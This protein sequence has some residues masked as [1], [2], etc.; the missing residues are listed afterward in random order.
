MRFL[1]NHP[2]GGVKTKQMR[3][4]GLRIG[5][6]I[7]GIDEDFDRY[8]IVVDANDICNVDCEDDNDGY[9]GIPLTDEWLEKLG[10]LKDEYG[11]VFIE[12]DSESDTRLYLSMKGYIQL[13]KSYHCPMFDYE[14]IRYVHQLQNLFFCLSGEELTIKEDRL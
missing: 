1:F 3:A 2:R 4:T 9:E 11:D 12:V 7:Y 8:L 5:N 10:A 14:H 13:V 6:F